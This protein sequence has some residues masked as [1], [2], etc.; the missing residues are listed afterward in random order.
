MRKRVLSI[1]L[2]LCMI[3]M[4][5]PAAA[6]ASFPDMPSDYS[7][8]AL[9]AAVENGLLK[10]TD[11]KIL[12]NENLTRAQ[13]AAI[14]V[15]AFGAKREASLAGYTDVSPQA[16]YYPELAKAV[17]MKVLQGDGTRLGTYK[18]ELFAVQEKD[19]TFTQPGS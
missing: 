16:W 15:R 13:M 2:A 5:M 18:F 9:E 14:I 10:G 11:G 19:Y 12:P 1:W 8:E 7:R 17:H 4:L 3:L 6:A